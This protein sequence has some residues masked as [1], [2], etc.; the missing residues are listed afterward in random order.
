MSRC[1]F[2]LTQTPR[3]WYRFV[4]KRMDFV[5]KMMN[6]MQTDRTSWR[7]VLG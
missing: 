6:F 5:F 2:C 1:N 4:F 7:L 3:I